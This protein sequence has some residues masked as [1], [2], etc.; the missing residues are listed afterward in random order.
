MIKSSQEL[1]GWEVF[2]PPQQRK[3]YQ[4]VVFDGLEANPNTLS[5]PKSNCTRLPQKGK[6]V[7]TPVC[8]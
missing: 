4:V 5:I 8:S 7:Y 1:R 3:S 2:G 6:D